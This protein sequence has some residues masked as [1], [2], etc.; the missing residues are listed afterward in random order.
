[1]LKDVADTEYV[2]R[3]PDGE[4]IGAAIGCLNSLPHVGY[5]VRRFEESAEETIDKPENP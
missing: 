1:L 3:I 5:A 2:L 4:D